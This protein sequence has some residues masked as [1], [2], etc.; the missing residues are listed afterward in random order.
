MKKMYAGIIILALLLGGSLFNVKY[1]ERQIGGLMD[2]VGR[3]Q[4]YLRDGDEDAAAQELQKAIDDWLSM[5]GYTHIFIRHSEIDGA[6]D[7]FYELKSELLSG[8]EGVDGAYGKI[9][10]HL[11]SLITI[12]QPSFG[13]IF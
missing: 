11:M 7:A 13:S 3:S 10:A 9:Q 12:E 6:T 1:L 2:T 4:Q 5:D 8:D